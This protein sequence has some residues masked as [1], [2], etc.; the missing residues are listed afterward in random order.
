MTGT[1]G[2]VKINENAQVVNNDGEVIGGLYAC[3]N[4]TA[5]IAGGASLGGGATLC[6]G[7]T[8]AY[9]AAHNALG[10]E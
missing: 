9:I 1:C 2:G 10:I 4:C 3:G 7:G 5:S 6:P 8:M